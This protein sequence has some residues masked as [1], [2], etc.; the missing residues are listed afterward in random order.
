VILSTWLRWDGLKGQELVTSGASSGPPTV[1]LRHGNV[2]VDPLGRLSDL[3]DPLRPF[4]GPPV[5][6]LSPGKPVDVTFA[7]LV[8]EAVG[9]VAL[10]VGG[11]MGELIALPEA[12][13]FE[14]EAVVGR[15]RRSP[16]QLGPIRYADALLDVISGDGGASGLI[17]RDLRGFTTFSLPAVSVTSGP[18]SQRQAAGSSMSLV[19]SRGSETT[20]A[21]LRAGERGQVLLLYV[22]RN[23]VVF[24]YERAQATQ[25]HEGV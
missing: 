11:Q 9:S 15:W 20:E 18:L 19:L 21:A 5:I 14:I 3:A 13:S 7:F 6:L 17:A 25:E 22:G 16:G 2:W 12:D 4:V 8:P 23:D 24:L 1:R 10:V